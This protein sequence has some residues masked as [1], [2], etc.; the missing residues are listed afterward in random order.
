MRAIGIRRRRKGY[1]GGVR[2]AALFASHVAGDAERAPAASVK[3][4]VERNEFVFAGVEPGQLHGAFDGFGAA[5]AEKCLGQAAR[6]DVG[7]LLRQVRHRLHVIDVR[8]AVDKL[9]HLRLGRRDHAGI[10]VS[11]VDHRDAGKAIEIF[12]S[13]DVGDGSATGFVDHNGHD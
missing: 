9:V 12:A 11:G 7:K 6:R 4:G 1:P 3:A 10:A 5:V 13:V 2:P 8:R